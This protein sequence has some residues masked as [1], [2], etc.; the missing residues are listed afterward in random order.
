MLPSSI[1]RWMILNASVMVRFC[2]KTEIRHVI[3]AD[4]TPAPAVGA[5]RM[6]MTSTVEARS[7]YAPGACADAAWAAT[8]CWPTA[9]Q[10][11]PV[12]TLG[13]TGDTSWQGPPSQAWRGFLGSVLETPA[14]TFHSSHEMPTHRSTGILPAWVVRTVKAGRMPALQ[15]R[16]REM[17]G[18]GVATISGARKAPEE[19]LIEVLEQLVVL[20]PFNELHVA[21]YDTH[22]RTVPMSPR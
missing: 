11:Q 1:V 17:S 13:Q 14:R 21:V 18:L 16:S 22:D 7:Q 15:P 9:A 19:V 10:T 6:G 12:K 8:A 5:R 2:R 20:L 3:R 4:D